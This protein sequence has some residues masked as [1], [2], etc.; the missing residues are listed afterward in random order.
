[1]GKAAEELALKVHGGDN[2]GDNDMWHATWTARNMVARYGMSKTFG[3]MRYDLSAESLPHDLAMQ[4]HTEASRILDEQMTA[5][6]ALLNE[7]KAELQSIA[8]E[9]YRHGYL[10]EKRIAELLAPSTAPS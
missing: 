7:R 4:V 10:N 5:V 8:G 9:L 6:K 1:A 3:R 2:G